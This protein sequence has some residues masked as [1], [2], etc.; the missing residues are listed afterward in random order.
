MLQEAVNCGYVQYLEK[1]VQLQFRAGNVAD[2]E[3]TL[4]RAVSTG[5]YYAIFRL[6]KLLDSTGRAN[7]VEHVLRDG[8]EAGS[9]DAVR[10][11]VNLLD[12]SNRSFEA[13]RILRQKDADG[14]RPA[15]H[16]LA[17]REFCNG[18][19]ESALRRL[20]EW[21]KDGDLVAQ[22]IESKLNHT[23][24]DDATRIAEQSAATPMPK[25]LPGVA[26]LSRARERP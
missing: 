16:M 20:R 10:S 3:R 22:D 1:L 15:G 5:N 2:A 9:P 26:D 24:V 6:I 7:E 17:I 25:A 19:A 18:N 14:V 23:L 12:Q 21:A 11:L 4:R 8:A 13:D